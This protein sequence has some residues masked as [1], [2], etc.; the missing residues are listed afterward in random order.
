M[1][2]SLSAELSTVSFEG[3]GEDALPVAGE[4]ARGVFFVT[5]GSE[6]V[7]KEE[8]EYGLSIVLLLL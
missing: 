1:V 8:E 4:A 2:V 3:M 7:E 5:A 6:S